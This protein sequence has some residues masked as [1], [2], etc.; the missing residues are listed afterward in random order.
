ME[1]H[2]VDCRRT[3]EMKI[4]TVGKSSITGMRE[5]DV[6]VSNCKPMDGV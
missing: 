3:L 5:T 1:E 6:C 4:V 2:R